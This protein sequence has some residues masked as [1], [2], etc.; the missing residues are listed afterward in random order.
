MVFNEIISTHEVLNI[1]NK[2]K[3]KTAAG[4]DGLPVKTFKYIAE[5][6]LIPLTD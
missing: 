3:D 5:C 4:P 6:I 1:I 2:L